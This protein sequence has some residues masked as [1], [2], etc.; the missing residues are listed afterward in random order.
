MIRFG[1]LKRVGR[2]GH[3]EIMRAGGVRIEF[4]VYLNSLKRRTLRKK[5]A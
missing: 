2:V 3:A 4:K 1:K 5:Y